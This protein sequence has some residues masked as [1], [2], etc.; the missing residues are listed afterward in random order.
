MA[1]IFLSLNLH[2]VFPPRH[3]GRLTAGRWDLGQQ[4]RPHL[5]WRSA[6]AW[7]P[8]TGLRPLHPGQASLSSWAMS[9][10]APVSPGS[11][12][13]LRPA[14]LSLP[15]L[16]QPCCLQPAGRLGLCHPQPPP[17][18]P[19][20][21]GTRCSIV[22]PAAAWSDVTPGWWGRRVGTGGK[23]AREGTASHSPWRR[24]PSA[25]PLTAP[26][27]PRFHC[28]TRA[29]L[30]PLSSPS[31]LQEADRYFVGGT[32][33]ARSKRLAGATQLL[34]GR[35]KTPEARGVLFGPV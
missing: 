18:R 12:P 20:P 5:A 14:H 22:R 17:P 35:A 10:P 21:P 2:L 30:H 34:R 32:P 11:L 1:F 28:V 3:T 23:L 26:A 27:Q 25:C 33:N 29:G 15:G 9:P 8:D 31:K 19:Q 4:Q 24:P 6:Q 7:P 13:S 16:F